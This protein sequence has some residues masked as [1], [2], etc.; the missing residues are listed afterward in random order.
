MPP[1]MGHRS[2]ERR[3]LFSRHLPHGSV[4]CG[5][6]WSV[7]AVKPRT[8]DVER[9]SVDRAPTCVGAQSSRGADRPNGRPLSRARSPA[10]GRA[11]RSVARNEA[12]KRR[13]SERARVGCCGELARPCSCLSCRSALIVPI[14]SCFSFL[15][16]GN[17]AEA[18]QACTRYAPKVKN[19]L[20]EACRTRERGAR[21]SRR[22]RCLERAPSRELA[23]AK[24][25]STY[26]DHAAG[27]EASV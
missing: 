8:C 11:M 6:V 22:S 17:L 26:A 4:R 19:S 21:E 1:R 16:G 20:P 25:T 24:K 13:T 3:L 5:I 27:R 23:H 7:V 14:G 18:H 12:R 10:R 15:G 2:T 9:G